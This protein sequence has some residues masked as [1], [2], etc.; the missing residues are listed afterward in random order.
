MRNKVLVELIVPEIE[1]SYNLYLPINK[2]IGESIELLNKA[3]YD[4]SDGI[5][6]GG[7]KNFLY[8]KDTG[9]RYDINKK[10]YDTDIRNGT[11]IILI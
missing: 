7:T 1:E 8:N 3:I 2:T 11:G 6:S 4:L 9:E 5:Y 10:I